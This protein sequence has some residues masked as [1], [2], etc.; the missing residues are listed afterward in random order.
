[1][2]EENRASA[3]R[4]DVLS[5]EMRVRRMKSFG[6]TND[7]AVEKLIRAYVSR[8]GNPHQACPEF[9]PDRA[10]AYIERS[11]TGSSRAQYEAHLYECGACRKGVVALVRMAEADA[12]ISVVPGREAARSTWFSGVSRM[13]GALSQPQWAMAAAAVIVLAISLPLFLSRNRVQDS[14]QA[15]VERIQPQTASPGAPPSENAAASAATSKQREKSDE[16]AELVARNAPAAP[17]TAEA[18]AGAGTIG[19][20]VKKPEVAD[21]VQPAEG[22]RKSEAPVTQTPAQGGAAPGSQVAKNDSDQGRQQQTE[23]DAAKVA[24][25]PQTVARAEES[26][27]DKAGKE[28]AQKTDEAAAPPPASSS[29]LA[30]SRA[31]GLR[32]PAKLSLRDSAPGEAV[33]ADERRLGGKKFLFRDGAW[34]DKDFD[35]NK[36]LPM[37][38]V[39]RDSNVYK[40]LLSKRA[41]LKVIMERFTSAERAIIVYKGTVYK[42]IPQ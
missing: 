25:E 17:K 3:L 24:A 28:K 15:I 4:A 21:A 19:P 42:L 32:P 29:E 35:P 14:S 9:D 20:L 34:T 37:V 39:I 10:N 33:R 26:A 38:T 40:E 30:R 12:V 36:D 11:L 23:K 13:F 31:G 27:A 7:G 41:G 2:I 22:Q 5:L 18:P 1:M 6:Q 8:P 16:K